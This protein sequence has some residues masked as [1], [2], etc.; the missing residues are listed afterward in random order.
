MKILIGADFVPTKSNEQLFIDGSVEELVGTDLQ[1]IIE[2]ADFRIFNLEMPLSD[3][4]EP[5]KKSGP[6]LIARTDTINAYKKLGCDLLTVA[7][8][9]IMD[10]GSQG[11]LSTL[12]IL[13]REGVAYVGAGKDLASA[14]RSMTFTVDGKTIGVY[15]CA[16]H[17]FSIAA[18]N[19]PGANPFDVL[20]SFDHVVDMKKKCDY[21]IV[22]YHGGKEYYRY[23]SPNLQRYCR[24]FVD[25]GADLVVC[26]HSHCIGCF[27]EYGSGTIVYGQGNFLF[28]HGDDEF[29]SSSLLVEV[30]DNFK[31]NYI[32]L[33]KRG[34]GTR[35]AAMEEAKRILGDFY[36]R[37]KEIQADGAV[38]RLYSS[39]AQSYLVNYLGSTAGRAK[40][41]KIYKLIN[42]LYKGR[43]L[44]K[45]YTQREKLS[46]IN[47]VDCEA[48]RELFLRGLKDSVK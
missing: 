23:P 41:S 18:E 24:K 8:N 6:A 12:S 13:E 21:I 5:I 42:K 2:S 29:W 22:L 7:N 35:L 34:A 47:I 10:Q 39:F 45:N 32:P 26:Q 1:N 4:A 44:E 37:S 17:E 40:K 11:L 33:V 31:I 27:E 3:K 36:S 14:S 38:E 19:T 16:E 43:L 48:H 25:K 20:E 30:S 15:A 9:H 28:D 46:L